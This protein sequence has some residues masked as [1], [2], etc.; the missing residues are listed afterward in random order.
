M[1]YANESEVTAARAARA[2]SPYRAKDALRW[3]AAGAA[4]FAVVADLTP[5]RGAPGVTLATCRGK[6]VVCR[7]A[8]SGRYGKS[9]AYRVV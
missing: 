4:S 8:S 1:K 9:V 5:F 2:L 6:H 3:L 7:P